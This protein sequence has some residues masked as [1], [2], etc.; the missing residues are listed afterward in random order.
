MRG[1]FALVAASGEQELLLAKGRFGGRP[2]YYANDRTGESLV[3]CS[4][5]GPL[6][7]TLE[8]NSLD[9][10]ALGTYLVWDTPPD[11]CQTLYRRVRR[12]PP[13]CAL[14]MGVDGVRAS[15]DLGCEVTP[16]TGRSIDELAQNLRDR[17]DRAIERAIGTTEDI[18][19][20]VSG[21]LDSSFLLATT[22]RLSR[23]RGGPRVH[24]LNL[25][26]AALGDDR[27]HLRDLC[28][29]LRI[30]AILVHPEECASLLL[31]SLVVDAAPVPWSGASFEIRLAQ[32]SRQRGASVLMTGIGGDDVFN[33]DFGVF[34]N[35]ARRGRWRAAVRDAMMLKGSR[36]A[37][38]RN[39]VRELVLYPI[40][41]DIIGPRW[42]EAVR[43]RRRSEISWAGPRLRTLIRHALRGSSADAG[44]SGDR[45]WF[46]QMSRSKY[47]VWMKEVLGQ[48]EI[49]GRCTRVQPYMDDELVEFLASLPP[50]TLFYGGW[51]RGLFR[52]AMRG[53]IPEG[54][55]TRQDKATLE[56]ALLELVRAAG[57]LEVFRPLIS[58]TGLAD[59]G[60]VEP[61]AFRRRFAELVETPLNGRLWIELWPALTA[62]AFVRGG[63]PPS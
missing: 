60:L 26:Y 44:R 27:P 15:Y 56:P 38:G 12:V 17:I 9:L 34:A 2:L 48:I 63:F 20:G 16:A 25:H 55:R 35:L 28:D 4:R 45:G 62:E 3:V 33:G 51:V 40:I 7:A 54:V 19:L 11:A 46:S 58:M 21:G 37:T 24:A 10:S 18:A 5:L 23:E 52:H 49:A 36:G 22:L 14:R 29:V 47:Y 59:H 43:A 8:D 41:R 32:L 57:G 50:E 39:R 61:K 53:I 1:D 13:A 31:D 30:E 42:S 6:V